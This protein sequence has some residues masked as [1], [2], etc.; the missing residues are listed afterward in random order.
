MSVSELH[1]HKRASVRTLLPYKAAYFFVYAAMAALM[2][3]LTLYYEHLGLTGRQIGMLA[4]LPPLLTFL[5][6]PLFGFLA[7]LTRHPKLLL[8]ISVMSVVIAI[9][10]LTRVQTYLNLILVI[11]FYALFFAPI[12]PIIDRSVLDILGDQRDQYGKQRLW[13]AVGWGIAAPF[14]GL[15]VD[16]GGLNWAFYSSAILF[17]GLLVLVGTMPVSIFGGRESFWLGFKKLVG[18]WPVI[19]FF[20]VALGGGVGLSMI[21]H[22]LFLFLDELG[23]S[24]L[25]MGWSLTIATVSELFVMFFSDRILRRWGARRLLLFSLAALCLRLFSYSVIHRPEWVLLIQLLHGPTFAALWMA[26]VAYVSEIAPPGLRNTSQGL[27]TGFV[28]GLGSMLGA[29]I[30]GIMYEQV[31][32]SIMFSYAGTGILVL[33]V[34]FYLVCRGRCQ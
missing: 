16:V 33:T 24:S 20:G 3:F 8:G 4:A 5:G 2:P 17:G 31:G 25:M 23:A 30:G 27:L 9:L 11:S 22:Y 14:A 1:S 18:N 28:M 26:A 13:G 21:H 29:L 6:A 7:D 12:L 10:A 19:A 34:S 32:F 15:L